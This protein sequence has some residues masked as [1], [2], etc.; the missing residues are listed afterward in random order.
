MKRNRTLSLLTT[1][2][3]M[4]AATLTHTACNSDASTRYTSL[5]AFFHFKP[6]SSIPVLQQALNN[7]GIYCKITFTPQYYLFENAQGTTGQA[8]R[9]ALDAYGKP[10]YVSGFVVG[11]SSVP[12]A[13][14]NFEP[15]AYDLV[16]PNCYLDA[17]IQRALAFLSTDS[18][19]LVCNR[20]HRH[21]N[22]RNEGIVVS[23][24]QGQPLFQYHIQSVSDAVY[25]SN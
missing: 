12:A 15:K 10:V 13:N 1:A 8:N 19:M 18:E 4:A 21:Y 3:L 9:T 17:A 5:R 22:L 6:V 2:L 23:G 24:S 25:I 14:G 11:L 16:C 20:C 7:P